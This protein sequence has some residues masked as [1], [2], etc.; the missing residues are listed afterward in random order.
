MDAAFLLKVEG[1]ARFI[2]LRAGLSADQLPPLLRALHSPTIDDYPAS[3]PVLVSA[4]HG[5]SQ[6]PPLGVPPRPVV[7]RTLGL[8]LSPA[9]EIVVRLMV[10]ES[11]QGRK[12]DPQISIDDLRSAGLADDDIEDA[13]DEL[14]IALIGRSNEI[15]SRIIYAQE[16]LFIRFD[17]LIHP[18]DAE[19]DALRI[20]ASMLNDGGDFL[21]IPKT[22]EAYGWTPRRMNP[23]LSFLDSRG[24]GQALRAMDPNYSVVALRRTPATRRF[25]RD[26]S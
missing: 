12:F 15:G 19:Q 22:A 5:I 23:A 20:A 2:P 21:D 24:L 4:I 16:E 11:K 7:N 6:R 17:S 13:V 18:W 26:N 14:G 10:A 9:A 8:G 3:L 1:S 25:V